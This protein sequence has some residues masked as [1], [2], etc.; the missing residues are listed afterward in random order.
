MDSEIQ[1]QLNVIIQAIL[2]ALDSKLHLVGN[3][4]AD[5]AQRLAI[6]RKIY[7]RGDF[8]SHMTYE[9]VKEEGRMILK[10]GSHVA[11]APYVT[12]GKVP[13]FTPI[14]PLIGWVERKGLSWVHREGA[15]QGKLL[16][17]LE[18]A[19]MIRS[20]IRRVGIGGRNIFDELLKN[21]QQWIFDELNAIQIKL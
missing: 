5:E 17:V 9:V 3:T 6:E 12:G 7:D 15:N 20:K 14:A 4:L 19:Y 1:G 2:A 18:M 10:V 21:K 8:A 13:S 16:S 11:H